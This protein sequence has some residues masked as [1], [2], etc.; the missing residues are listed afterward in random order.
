MLASKPSFSTTL[1]MPTSQTPTTSYHSGP[2]QK[3]AIF[4]IKDGASFAS[5]TESEFSIHDGLEAVR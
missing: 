2:S 4:S 1:G 5:P 3:S